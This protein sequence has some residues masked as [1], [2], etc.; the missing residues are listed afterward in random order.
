MMMYFLSIVK[1]LLI[2]Y[3]VTLNI[4]NGKANI[5]VFVCWFVALSFKTTL[6]C[7]QF[8]IV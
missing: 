2:I 4:D 6:L 8:F 3:K 1:T 5:Q 7:P